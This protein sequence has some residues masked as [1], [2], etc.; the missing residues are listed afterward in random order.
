MPQKKKKNLEKPSKKK[1]PDTDWCVIDG[2]DSWGHY[3]GMPS[4]RRYYKGKL[5]LSSDI[6][7]DNLKTTEKKRA[8]PL[9]K[10]K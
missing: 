9:K 2:P 3:E 6:E 10:K 4:L 7:S 8:N 5:R 1:S